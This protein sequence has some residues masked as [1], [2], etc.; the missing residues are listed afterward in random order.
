MALYISCRLFLCYLHDI[1]KAFLIEAGVADAR[2]QRYVGPCWGWSI[3]AGLSGGI[4][5]ILGRNKGA[6][7]YLILACSYAIFAVF[8][9]MVAFYLSAVLLV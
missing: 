6:T 2:D 1:F 7:A 3:F 4:S 8:N 5:D 9:S